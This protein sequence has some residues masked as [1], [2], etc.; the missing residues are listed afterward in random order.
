MTRTYLARAASAALL[1]SCL[2]ACTL[3]GSALAA[4]APRTLHITWFAWPPAVELQQLGNLYASQHPGVAIKVD[5]VPLN[6][7]H[8]YNFN[9][10][11]AHRTNFVA[12]V[13]DSQWLGE[14]VSGGHVLELSSWLK[15]NLRVTDFYPY[16]FAAYSQYPQRLPG[17]T[18]VLNLNHGH[19]YGIPW[20]ADAMGFAYRKDWFS[21]PANQ[22]AFMAR[23][24]HPLAVPQSMDQIVEIADFFTNPA[25]GRYGIAVHEQPGYD[26]A[27]ETFNSWCWNYGG[28]L[29]DPITGQINGYINSARCQHALTLLDHLTINDSPPNSGNNFIAE[30][31]ADMTGGKVALIQNWWGGM[32]GL[33]ATQ[34]NTLGKTVPQ[35]E[36]KLGF[37]NMPGEAY[38]GLSARWTA[39]GGMGLSISS[40]APKADQAAMLGFAKWFLSTPVQ[41]LW[42]K[43]GGAPAS[44]LILNSPGFLSAEPWNPVQAQSYTFVKDFWNMP[45]YSQMLIEQTALV[46]ASMIGKLSPKDALNRIATFQAGILR[47]TGE[48]PYYNTH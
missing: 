1:T 28:D 33:L 27:S 23:Y 20:E 7:W 31:D 8:D 3:T 25:K 13:M 32:G 21:D 14:A 24:H 6:D 30:V 42:Y 40:Y 41:T 22:K 26:A 29:W 48:Y 5:A 18:G 45:E 19:F 39:L 35:I 34:G 46:N 17:E 9:Q 16:L 47:K 4:P 12:A 2:A 36:S 43:G 11:K 38:Q 15:Q 44:T 10:F 37:F